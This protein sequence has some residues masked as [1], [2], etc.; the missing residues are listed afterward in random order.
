MLTIKV[1]DIN[2]SL[3]IDMSVYSYT[4]TL[5]GSITSDC[6]VAHE[7]EHLLY[8]KGYSTLD[9]LDI[10]SKQLSLHG[11]VVHGSSMCDNTKRKNWMYDLTEWL[12]LFNPHTGEWLLNVDCEVTIRMDG[13]KATVHVDY[14]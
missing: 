8:R 11:E 7:V 1:C 2:N 13:S 6:V 14:N 3:A 5:L 12:A 10:Q 9:E 4:N